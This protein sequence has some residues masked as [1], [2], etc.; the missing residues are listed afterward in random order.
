[1]GNLLSHSASPEFKLM[2]G[3]T[4]THRC[5]FK[6]CGNHASR[7][8]C[9]VQ[10]Q[11]H[12]LDLSQQIWMSAQPPSKTPP[13]N[14]FQQ[15]FGV[16]FAIKTYDVHRIDMSMWSLIINACSCCLWWLTCWP[17]WTDWTLVPETDGFS[18]LLRKLFTGAA[19]S[20]GEGTEICLYSQ[21]LTLYRPFLKNNI[22][23][24]DL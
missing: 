2:W 3:A 11:T 22:L 10:T 5:V 9:G 14:F 15:I 21:P 7:A 19:W 24:H 16:F 13:T 1:M 12:S 18:S 8:C 17:V 20:Q 4:T 23:A 6:L